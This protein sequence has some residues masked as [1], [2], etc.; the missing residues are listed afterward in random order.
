MGFLIDLRVF[1]FGSGRFNELLD[2]VVGLSHTTWGGRLNPIVFLSSDT[3]GG[4]DWERLA[5]ADVDCLKAFAPLS[6]NLLKELDER[7]QP[8]SVELN[9]FSD[10]S[11]RIQLESVGVAA[12]PSEHTLRPFRGA[13]LVVFGFPENA[14][15]LLKRFVH[16]NF[17]TYRQ[18]INPH[19]GAVLR[20]AWLESLLAKAQVEHLIVSDR[21]ALAEA[22]TLLVGTQ[23]GPGYKAPLRFVAPNELTSVFLPEV[24]PL[25]DTN[26]VYQ[27]IVGDSAPD[28]SEHWNE[29]IWKRTWAKPHAW[30]LW[31]PPDF[32]RDPILQGAL[33]NWLR[34][35]TGVGNSNA[36]QVEFISHS[37]STAELGT[38]RQE[39][40]GN[41]GGWVPWSRVT[42]PEILAGRKRK[43]EERLSSSRAAI[44][45]NVGEA[46]RYSASRQ[47][48]TF[49]LTVPEILA[50]GVNPDGVWMVDV[51]IREASSH[52]CVGAK[53]SSWIAPRLNSGGLI[54][55]MFKNAARVNRDGIF[56][57][58]VENES[59]RHS[60]RMKPEFTLLL[61][62]PPQVLASLITR[63]TYEPVFTADSRYQRA[64]P[65]RPP[66]RVRYSDKGEYLQGLIRI[67]G[68]FWT[69][70]RFCER[71][72]WRQ[73]FAKLANCDAR[74]DAA[75]EVK[76][77]NLL[78]KREQAGDDPSYLASRILGLM[79]GRRSSGVALPYSDFQHLAD[80]L[81]NASVPDPYSCLQGNVVVS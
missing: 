36:K 21:K 38:L 15:P 79:R 58:R 53:E 5:T 29:E 39:I 30:H 59:R 45:S 40:C 22:L 44:L 25:S 12:I 73:M 67:F 28:F 64:W 1:E 37:L 62:S 60:R 75:L 52:Q 7:L 41:S 51:Q 56:S 49:S 23:P 18:E 24:W 80:E 77:S 19:T 61:P 47:K 68:D 14:D 8:W 4:A 55:A 65:R 43:A 31:V 11:S 74:K 78:R 6:D 46:I 10:P 35:Y 57:L 3:L 81:L 33:R 27:V 54:S 42:A 16:W 17:G 32:A 26:S 9:D 71:R 76:I 13:K 63:P 34:H 66:M 48:E 70:K 2:A 20:E 50:D 69:A 72:F